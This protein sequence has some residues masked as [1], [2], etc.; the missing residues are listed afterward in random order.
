M[1]K[2]FNNSPKGKGIRTFLQTLIAVL[3]YI[4]V[5]ANTPELME[6]ASGAVAWTSVIIPVLSGLISYWM[7][8]KGM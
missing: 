4:A 8:K 3:P 2:A 7:N 1:T 6:A 5:V